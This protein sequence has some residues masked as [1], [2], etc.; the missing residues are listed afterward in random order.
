MGSGSQWGM[1]IGAAIGIGMAFATGGASLTFGAWFAG[2][3][4]AA[5]YATAIGAGIGGIAGGLI[6]PTDFHGPE[7]QGP[8]ISELSLMGVSE[9]TGVTRCYGNEIRIAG[10]LIAAGGLKE[11]SHSSENPTQSGKSFV[12]GTPIQLSSG[13]M[14]GLGIY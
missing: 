8:R 10:Q 2:N 7:V 3:M 6:S 4:G 12:A 9:G 5:M 1:I 11:E 13:Q 14:L